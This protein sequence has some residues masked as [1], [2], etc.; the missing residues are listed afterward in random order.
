MPAKRKEELIPAVTNLPVSHLPCPQPGTVQLR[1]V[2]N[3]CNPFV[4]IESV[5][6]HEYL[7]RH[8]AT[9]ALYEPYHVLDTGRHV[10]LKFG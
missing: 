9:H 10:G 8:F 4:Q 5:I 2:H 3:S 1:D 6:S 7:I